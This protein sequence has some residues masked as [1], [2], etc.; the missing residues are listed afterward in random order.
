MPDRVPCVISG[1]HWLDDRSTVPYLD[2]FL[3]ALRGSSGGLRV[4]FTTNGRSTS[5][6]G[7]LYPSE[8]VIVQSSDLR[9]SDLRLDII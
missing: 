5:L 9:D 6:R 2:G 3:E 8:T 1:L 4:L 7:K